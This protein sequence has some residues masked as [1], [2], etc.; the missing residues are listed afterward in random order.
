[1]ATGAPQSRK[2]RFFFIPC[3]FGT[4]GIFKTLT[5]IAAGAPQS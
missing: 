1:M 4:F 2:L 3:F 5:N